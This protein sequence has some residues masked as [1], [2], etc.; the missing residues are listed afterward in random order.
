MTEQAYDIINADDSIKTLFTLAL[1]LRAS[2]IHIEPMASLYRIRLRIDGVLQ[3]LCELEQEKALRLINQLKVLAHLDITEK[4]LPLDGRIQFN[5]NERC[6]DFR[7]STCPTLLGEKV[8]IR[9]LQ[10][11]IS[12]PLMKELGLDEEQ[13]TLFY[14]ALN[15]SNGMILVTGP[16]GSGKTT[17]LYS[18]LHFKNSITKNIV[19]I[20]DP[21]E[22]Q[23]KGI[24][25]VATHKKIGLDFATAL[26]A[27][28]RQDP[29]IIMIGE[30]RD[31]ETAEIA[32]K[33]AE[34]GHLVLST[35]HTS[36]SL[37]SLIRLINMDI[38]P[39]H[40]AYGLQLIIAQRLVRKLCMYC[41]KPKYHKILGTI[42]EP[43]Q[44]DVCTNGYKGRIGVF[45]LLKIDDT[46]REKLLTNQPIITTNIEQNQKKLHQSAIN[47][48]ST[49]I[50]SQEELRNLLPPEYIWKH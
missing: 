41:K 43:N 26:R 4:R 32:I 22:I 44:C 29:D 37:E 27:F 50:S 2:D 10:E 11:A 21:I 17:T 39:M 33:A 1:N 36:N 47:L 48:L 19:T 18:A 35:L 7:I 24:N 6:Y 3:F 38:N 31:N 30:I 15:C 49:G 23:L 16:N 25:Q 12:L 8:V 45:E 40:I 42:F 28:L 14:Q 34:T 46:I 20:E 13:I 5:V 9:I